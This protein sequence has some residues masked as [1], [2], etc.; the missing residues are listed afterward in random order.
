MKKLL[1]IITIAVL[2]LSITACSGGSD[3]EMAKKSAEGFLDAFVEL[4]FETIADYMVEPDDLPE[5]VKS[6]NLD[7]LMDNM[8]EEM[9]PYKED[10]KTVFDGLIGAF[11]KKMDYEILSITPDGADYVVKADITMPKTEGIDFENMFTDA[12]TEEEITQLAIRLLAEG[13]ITADSTP[14]E[15][16]GAIMPTMIEKFESV[17][18]G[19]QLETYTEEVKMTVVNK[20][21]KW[22]IDIG[23]M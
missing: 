20:D 9:A 15:I 8:G 11:S 22:L 4:D 13:K 19:L 17:L 5:E 14:E 10:F 12:F 7:G 23:E 1:S 16:M 18:E 21:G 6:L 3:E 2:T